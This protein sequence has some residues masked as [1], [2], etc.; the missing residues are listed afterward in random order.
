MQD[1]WWKRAR[2]DLLDIVDAVEVD[3]PQAARHLLERI[4]DR[5]SRLGAFEKLGRSGRAPQTRELPITGSPY[6]AIYRVF[7]GHVAIVRLLHGR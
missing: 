4:G 1:K 3:R 6:A 7:S 5:V 2:N